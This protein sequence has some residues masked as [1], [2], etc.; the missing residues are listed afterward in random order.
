MRASGP[1]RWILVT[2]VAACLTALGYWVGTTPLAP[3]LGKASIG[4]VDLTRK[5]AS[6]QI[7]FIAPERL[8][9]V[10]LLLPNPLPGSDNYSGHPAFPLVLRLRI[11]DESGT[12]VWNEL[13]ERDRLQWTSWHPGPSLLLSVQSWL[14]EKM[15]ATKPYVLILTV[16]E[17]VDGLGNAEVYLHWRDIAYLWGTKHQM[18]TVVP[19]N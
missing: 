15:A 19:N 6:S 9:S 5:G 18:L 12:N 4:K 17:P 16:E 7:G 8:S 1:R 11:S 3:I 13:V 2:V 14:S 10:T